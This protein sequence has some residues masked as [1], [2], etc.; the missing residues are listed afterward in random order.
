VSCSKK[1]IDFKAVKE[2]SNANKS[3]N[4]V[5]NIKTP[6]KNQRVYIGNQINTS[7]E[8]ENN[9]DSELEMDVDY[10][11]YDL[12]KDRVI[13]KERT[14]FTIAKN[15]KK[16]ITP[17]ITVEQDLNED[18]EYALLFRAIG[19]GNKSRYYNQNYVEINI[20]RKD[21]DVIFN[22][23]EISQE[24][25]LVCGDYVDLNVDLI[26]LGTSDK[27]V[28]LVIGNSELGITEKTDSFNV[29]EYDSD[30]KVNRKFSLKIPENAK[31]GD[32]KLTLTLFTGYS[33]VIQEK[34]IT[35]NECDIL[36]TTEIKTTEPIKIGELAESSISTEPIINE[37]NK[38]LFLILNV[39]SICL[40]AI[41]LF[42]LF[43]YKKKLYH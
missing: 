36:T 23:I 27:S 29:A 18:N 1:P 16:T 17:N 8:I 28:Y 14:S 11:L 31:A 7:L 20:D 26:N 22:N 35:L 6:E 21:Y 33:N 37:G 10:Y 32:Y 9:I 34:T 19:D 40:F 15:S 4:I 39:S 25:G 24:S 3:G 43:A 42:G 2:P 30:E 12:T 38:T 5:L 41:I 13:S